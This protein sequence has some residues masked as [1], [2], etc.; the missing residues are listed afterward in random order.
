MDESPRISFFRCSLRFLPKAAFLLGFA[1]LLLSLSHYSVHDMWDYVL[2][3][4]VFALPGGLLVLCWLRCIAGF[5]PVVFTWEG[6][7]LRSMW[8]RKR[9]VRWRD[10]E[11]VR[12]HEIRAQGWT[13]EGVHLVLRGDSRYPPYDCR[14][15]ESRKTVAIFYGNI[16][17]GGCQGLIDALW[18]GLRRYG[19]GGSGLR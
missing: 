8:G 18:E 19:T 7:E 11:D 14:Y 17:A 10:I 4:G 1:W 5:R 9:L 3:L 15:A 6:V 2:L 16:M 13:S 12:I